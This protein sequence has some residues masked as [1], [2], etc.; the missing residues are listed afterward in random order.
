M[1]ELVLAL[2]IVVGGGHVSCSSMFL[3]LLPHELL[4][5]VRRSSELREDQPCHKQQLH[6]IPYGNPT[7][8]HTI[9]APKKKKI[10]VH[11]RKRPQIVNHRI[12]SVQYKYHCKMDWRSISMRVRKEYKIQYASHCSSSTFDGLSIAITDAYLP[13]TTTIFSPNTINKSKK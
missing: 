4:I 3:D 2:G 8:D 6:I 5:Y 9:Q 12:S 7:Y 13:C 10:Q 11:P 1:N